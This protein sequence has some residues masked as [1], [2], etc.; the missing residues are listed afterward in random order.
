M[1]DRA[2]QV[3]D[4]E[5]WELYMWLGNGVRAHA[6]MGARDERRRRKLTEDIVTALRL[7]NEA[8]SAWEEWEARL[9]TTDEAWTHGLPQMTPE[10]Y[11]EYVPAL[12]NLRTLAGE[13]IAKAYI[14]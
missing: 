4:V 11:D 2:E 9:L 8:L 13:A 6:A 12:Q 10:L 7:A 3:A 5:A 14:A 1:T